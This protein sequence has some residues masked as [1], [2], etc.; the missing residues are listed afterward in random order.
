MLYGRVKSRTVS[1]RN[2]VTL[3]FSCVHTVS[4][5]RCATTGARPRWPSRGRRPV[6]DTRPR[7]SRVARPAVHVHVAR[8]RRGPPW[9]KNYNSRL[10]TVYLEHASSPLHVHL[11]RRTKWWP[12]RCP[13]GL[14]PVFRR[15]SLR[16]ASG[17]GSG[18][19]QPPLPVD[20]PVRV[21]RPAV[22]IRSITYFSRDV[23][24]RARCP[25]GTG[26]PQAD[27][28]DFNSSVSRHGADGDGPRSH[29]PRGRDR[30]RGQ[31]RARTHPPGR[32]AGGPP[33][34]A[35]SAPRG[36][37]PV[38]PGNQARIIT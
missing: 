3:K 5:R 17:R 10:L 23:G 38:P 9:K 6:A 24:S 13:D 33:A 25:R 28:G 12:P 16:R 21:S 29:V 8:A 14:D 31:V 19:A 2:G 1:E 35:G 27:R 15:K 18:V 20:A 37:R 7:T 36:Y 26:R 11:P 4:N 34:H 22:K 32:E 30:G